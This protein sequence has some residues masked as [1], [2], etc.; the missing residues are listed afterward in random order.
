MAITVVTMH[1]RFL[2]FAVRLLLS[3]TLLAAGG[4]PALEHAHAGG[5]KQHE[6]AALAGHS[7][8]HGNHVADPFDGYENP[9]ATIA[10]SNPVGHLHVSWLGII[11]TIP[12]SPVPYESKSD[13][14]NPTA[15]VAGLF[16]DTMPPTQERSAFDLASLGTRLDYHRPVLP[17]AP[18]FACTPAVS[19]PLCDTARHERSGVQLI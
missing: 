18:R 2:Q 6:H 19:A 12:S 8:D 3:A 4:A 7:H 16:G 13:A 17:F 11:V 14:G 10:I 5:D 1:F 15:V 9:T